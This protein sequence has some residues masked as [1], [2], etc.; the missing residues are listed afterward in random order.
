MGLDL[1]KVCSGFDKDQ[2]QGTFKPKKG[3]GYISFTFV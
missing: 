1:L 2:K 3:L